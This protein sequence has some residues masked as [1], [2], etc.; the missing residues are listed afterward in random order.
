MFV[1]FLSN[2]SQKLQNSNLPKLLF[3]TTPGEIIT[4]KVV[5]WSKRKLK[6]VETVDIGPG[7]HYIQEDNPHTIGDELSKY[8]RALYEQFNRV[9]SSLLIILLICR[10]YIVT[11]RRLL[12]LPAGLAII[13]L[14]TGNLVVKMGVPA[15]C[16][17]ILLYALSRKSGCCWDA[18]WV[19]VAFFFSAAGDFSF[20]PK[21]HK[22]IFR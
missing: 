5:E 18:I 3:Y 12:L 22:Q 21:G 20:P 1:D 9:F 19:V 11:I 4:P 17:A 10:S 8:Y 16:A 2:Y 13:A 6:N 7:I 15:S 14:L